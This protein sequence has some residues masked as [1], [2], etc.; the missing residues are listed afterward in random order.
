MAIIAFI[1]I[2]GL[3]LC[4]IF[5]GVPIGIALGFSPALYLILFTDFQ[6]TLI[7]QGFFSYLDSFIFIAAPLFIFG[8][9]LSE[10]CDILD[11]LFD[12]TRNITQGLPGGIG[13]GFMICAVL[14]GAITG[15]S[16]A[17]AAALSVMFLPIM[18][19]Y[20][21]DESF[22]TGMICAGGG[23]AMLIP[24]SLPLIVYGSITGTSVVSLFTAGIIPGI[25]L[26]L[27]FSLHLVFNG[28]RHGERGGQTNWGELLSAVRESL[29]AVFM[30][31]L[32]LSIIYT[33]ITTPTEAAGV[34]IV[35]VSIYGIIKS[36]TT[37][38]S[39]IPKTLHQTLQ[40][41]SKLW[42]LIGGAGIL[43]QVLIIEQIP[44]QLID[45]ILETGLGPRTFLFFLSLFFLVM[46][47][48]MDGISLLVVLMPVVFPIAESLKINPVFL[49]IMAVVNLEM[50]VI[51]PPVGLNLYTVSGI[52][53]IPIS[54]V[55][56][57]SIPYLTVT[58]FFLI[59]IIFFPE[60]VLLLV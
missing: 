17:S 1:F 49:G 2:I 16:V 40:L 28:W 20:R 53:G 59:F 56:K 52:A 45:I 25:T 34:M 41:T 27:L 3:F 12:L 42:L 38:V 24:P 44:S 29:G 33:G 21:Y 31:V 48:F 23:I 26:G 9:K 46:G 19:K 13:V 5:I 36:G 35:Y 37:F 32:I 50:A 10:N 43:S 58:A 39:K 60:F 7:V 55:F 14:F 18:R 51:T 8:G 4:L 30:P 11:V 54:K 47:M 15:L 6:L 57:G 22:S